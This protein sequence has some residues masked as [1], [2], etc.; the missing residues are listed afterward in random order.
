MAHVCAK[1]I[2]P[3]SQGPE[4]RPLRGPR[5]YGQQPTAA[6]YGHNPASSHSFPNCDRYNLVS[7]QRGGVYQKG[8]G[9]GWGSWKFEIYFEDRIC[10]SLLSP[11]SLEKWMVKSWKEDRVSSAGLEAILQKSL[12]EGKIWSDLLES[13]YY[14]PLPHSPLSECGGVVTQQCNERQFIR[15]IPRKMKRWFR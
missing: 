14:S 10:L 15:R 12:S 11:P 6:W 4:E 2:L 13:L 7:L 9:E 5:I 8:W 1:G 3:G